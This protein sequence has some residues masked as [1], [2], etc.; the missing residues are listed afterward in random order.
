MNENLKS[1]SGKVLNSRIKLTDGE[2]FTSHEVIQLVCRCSIKETISDPS[3]S[4]D[5]SGRSVMAVWIE[6]ASDALLGNF[7]N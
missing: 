1:Q 7:C 2:R 4:V 5:A 3:T 6:E